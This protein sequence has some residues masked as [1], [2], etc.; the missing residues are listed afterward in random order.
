[1]ETTAAL[2]IVTHN[3]ESFHPYSDENQKNKIIS[4]HQH[5]HR[6]EEGNL[7]GTLFVA[8]TPIEKKTVKKTR[9]NGQPE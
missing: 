6:I 9:R 8:G 1:M 3:G 5:A 2:K 7:T 4:R